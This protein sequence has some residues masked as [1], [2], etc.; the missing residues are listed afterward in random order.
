VFAVRCRK[1]VMADL[2]RS[3]DGGRRI[4]LGLAVAALSVLWTAPLQ[5]R[6][7]A[8]DDVFQQAVNYVFTGRIDPPNAPEI[9]D[10]SACIVV[11][12]DTKFKRY[13]RYYLKR[14]KMDA[15]RIN[16]TYSGSQ[17][18]Y[19]LEVGGDDIVVEF[20]NLDKTTVDFGLKTAHISLPGNID[21]EE[22]ALRRIFDEY[23]KPEKPKLPF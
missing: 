1:E 3:N 20:L 9:V 13:I 2:A 6:A 19:E 8:A 23:C 18:L 5:N 21:Q 14:F 22:R 7:E 17:A 15:S 10:R 16:K 12:P 4:G 11:V